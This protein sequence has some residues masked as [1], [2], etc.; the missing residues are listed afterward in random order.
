[1]QFQGRAIEPI[2]IGLMVQASLDVTVP[3]HRITLTFFEF[4]DQAQ[5]EG[6]RT[7]DLPEV[8]DT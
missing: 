4:T 5:V 2:S 1:M 7:T 8:N 6:V 3:H